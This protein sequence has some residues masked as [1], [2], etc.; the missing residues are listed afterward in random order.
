[1]GSRDDRE[2]E[3]DGRERDEDFGNARETGDGPQNETFIS[4][5][6]QMVT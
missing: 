2:D 5:W 3:H 4:S 6:P 1:M